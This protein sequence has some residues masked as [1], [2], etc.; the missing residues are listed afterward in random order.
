MTKPTITQPSKYYGV[1]R[2]DSVELTQDAAIDKKK[3]DSR[4]KAQNVLSSINVN[5]P[6]HM[7]GVLTVKVIES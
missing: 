7:H 4:S 1:F 2:H 6:K 5:L 3:Y